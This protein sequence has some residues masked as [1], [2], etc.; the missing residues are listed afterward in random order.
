VDVVQ[1]EPHEICG[2]SELQAQLA[3]QA[4]ER[5]DLDEFEVALETGVAIKRN[6]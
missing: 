6:V 1:A 4:T 3:E 2:G 5:L